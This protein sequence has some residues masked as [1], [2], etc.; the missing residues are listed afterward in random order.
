MTW[1]PS[2]HHCHFLVDRNAPPNVSH[3]SPC[4]Y[5]SKTVIF[6]CGRRPA[7]LLATLVVVVVVVVVVGGGGITFMHGLSR[8]TMYGFENI[9]S[10]TPYF[11]SFFISK[12]HVWSGR[13]CTMVGGSHPIL[14]S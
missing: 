4:G 8:E 10:K 13:S 1:H 9:N 14:K 11:L 5:V 6:T 12:A 3:C 7:G 2:T